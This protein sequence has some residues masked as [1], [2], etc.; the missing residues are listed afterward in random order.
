MNYRIESKTQHTG[1]QD[2]GSGD[3]YPTADEALAAAAGL[4]RS[5]PA[6][7]D[8]AKISYRVVD[9][10]GCEIEAAAE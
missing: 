2:E 4:R 10:D 7:D 8:G 6:N 5:D 9:S 1:W 3:A